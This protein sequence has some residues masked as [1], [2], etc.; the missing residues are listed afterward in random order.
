MRVLF[1]FLL[2]YGLCSMLY[3]AEEITNIRTSLI[4]GKQRIVIDIDGSEEPAY[5]VRKDK[6]TID[7][8]IERT[9]PEGKA[10]S[11]ASLLGNTNYV[12]KAQFIILPEE[13][14]TIISISTKG[15]VSDDV[16]AL[17]NPSRIVIDL[18]KIKPV[19]GENL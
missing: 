7:V 17:A 8:T 15:K 11:F 19:K 9:L 1:I 4:K 2:S 3:P 16:F 12:R 13:K 14:E 10:E 18:E 6:E 5:Y